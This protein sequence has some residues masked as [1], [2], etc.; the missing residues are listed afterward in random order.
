[1]LRTDETLA[2]AGGKGPNVARSLSVLGYPARVVGMIGG[3]TGEL[4]AEIAREEGLAADWTRIAGETRTCV[5]LVSAEAGTATVINELGPAVDAEEWRTFEASATKA[6]TSAS[7]VC[8]A[9]SLP[10]S[11]SAEQYGALVA[12]LTEANETVYVDA[13]GDALASAIATRPRAIKINADEAAQILDRP[14]KTLEDGRQC[15]YELYR[16]GI[17]EVVITLGR[18]GAV[19]VNADGAAAARPPRTATVSSVGSGDAFLAAYIAAGLAGADALTALRHGVA[20]GSANARTPWGG[21][22]ERSDYLDALAVAEAYA[23][24]DAIT[25]DARSNPLSA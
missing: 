15:G 1:V 16:S 13:H 24:H 11:I 9:G 8:I 25:R 23:D 22:F 20:A 17:A 3:R 21:V 18:L 4:V 5:I 6:A 2:V 10:P 14:I 7:A 19:L 12:R